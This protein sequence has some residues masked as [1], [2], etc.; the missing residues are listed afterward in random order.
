MVDG[1]DKLADMQILR[2]AAQRP[3]AEIQQMQMPS[4]DAGLQN[5]IPG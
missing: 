4:P 3:P 1:L 2:E 5:I